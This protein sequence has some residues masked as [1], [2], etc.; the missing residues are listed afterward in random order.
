MPGVKKV[1]SVATTMPIPAQTM[2][3]R[4]VTGDAHGLE[5]KDEKYC[6]DEI[7]CVDEKFCSHYCR[8]PQFFLV[9]MASMRS[10]TT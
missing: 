6:D 10:V 2:P 9:N 1:T 7:G 4:A 8:P 3:L 5:A